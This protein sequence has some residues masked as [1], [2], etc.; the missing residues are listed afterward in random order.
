MI[1][2][3]LETGGIETLI[4]RATPWLIDNGYEVNLLLKKKG[5]LFQ[6]L[7]PRV[8]VKIYSWRYIFLFHP[9]F[10]KFLFSDKFYNDFD[11]VYTFRPEGLWIASVLTKVKKRPLQVFNCVYH[12]SEFFYHGKNHYETHYYPKII[13]NGFPKENLAFMNLPCKV[14]HEDYFNILLPQSPILPLAVDTTH[15]RQIIR[16]PLKYKIVSIGNFKP[17]KTYNL[18]MIDVVDRLIK[19]GFD[20]QYEIFGDG[21]QKKEMLQKIQKLNLNKHIHLKGQLRHEQVRD[22]LKDAYIFVGCGTAAIEAALCTIPTVVGIVDIQEPLTYGYLHD[23]PGFAV[24]EQIKNMPLYSVEELIK[25]VFQMTENEYEK[26]GTLS[27]DY[28]N[29]YDFETIMQQMNRIFSDDEKI[30]SYDFNTLTN[31]DYFNFYASRSKH[32]VVNKFRRLWQM[33]SKGIFSKR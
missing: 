22:A 13:L 1:Y 33:M 25:K 24:G 9:F 20:I 29:Q 10:A 3:H 30:L 26:I 4:L 16:T 27:S 23:M 11:K 7:D 32:Y 18:Y 19:Q 8:K 28:A 21:E 31:R 14:S 15:Y 2:D 17:F 6:K 12:P 5:N